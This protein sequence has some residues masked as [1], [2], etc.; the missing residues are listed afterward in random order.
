MTKVGPLYG[1]PDPLGSAGAPGGLFGHR[2]VI[3]AGRRSGSG[4]TTVYADMRMTRK[5]FQDGHDSLHS[6][7]RLLEFP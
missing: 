4:D 2:E 7:A 6:K 5:D 1:N 3:L